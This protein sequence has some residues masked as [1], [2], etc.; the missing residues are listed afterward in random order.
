MIRNWG[1]NVYIWSGFT[2]INNVTSHINRYSMKT[3]TFQGTMSSCKHYFILLVCI[4]LTVWKWLCASMC[5]PCSWSCLRWLPILMSLVSRWQPRLACITYRSRTWVRRFI[6]TGWLR[7][8][9]SLWLPWGTS[10]IIS[11]CRKMP[12]LLY[13]VTGYYKMW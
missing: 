9:T 12:C 10:P 4:D 13:V 3:L 6:V 11:S 7:W 2:S 8:S 1:F 5:S